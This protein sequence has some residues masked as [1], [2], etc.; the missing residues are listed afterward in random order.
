MRITAQKAPRD[1]DGGSMMLR[2]GARRDDVSH[3]VGGS[4]IFQIGDG[5]EVFRLDPDGNVVIRG[6]IVTKDMAMYQAFAEWLRHAGT[7]YE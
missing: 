1:G 2:A 5:T 7:G 4:L 3:T 6:D